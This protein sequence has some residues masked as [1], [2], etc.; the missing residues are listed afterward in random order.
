MICIKRLDL[1]IDAACPQRR[2]ATGVLG[3]SDIRAS[4]DASIRRTDPAWSAIVHPDSRIRERPDNAFARE[5]HPRGGG[6]I[7]GRLGLL[8]RA[9]TG[10]R[11]I[12]CADPQG[13]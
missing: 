8:F 9:G 10:L 7:S 1:L 11:P 4:W 5:G 12:G 2:S 3:A 13:V 6:A